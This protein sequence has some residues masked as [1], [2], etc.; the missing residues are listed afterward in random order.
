MSKRIL[1]PYRVF[2]PE[3]EDEAL[4]W[5]KGGRAAMEHSVWRRGS[6]APMLGR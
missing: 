6:P 1:I 5:V 3:Q 2:E 4:A